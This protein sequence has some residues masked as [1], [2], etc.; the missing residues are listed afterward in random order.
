VPCCPFESALCLISLSFRWMVRNF[1]NGM[2]S[3]WVRVFA[4]VWAACDLS[5]MSD[6]NRYRKMNDVVLLGKF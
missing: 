5:F 3:I 4:A 1:A 2:G 6:A